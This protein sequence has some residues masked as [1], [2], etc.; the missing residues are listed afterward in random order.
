MLVYISKDAQ[1]ACRKRPSAVRSRY[2]FTVLPKLSLALNK[3]YYT[4]QYASSQESQ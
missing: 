4:T 3:N 2:V 1:L